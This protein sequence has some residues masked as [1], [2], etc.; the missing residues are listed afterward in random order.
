MN[1]D[2]TKTLMINEETKEEEEQENK[3]IIKNQGYKIDT[4]EKVKPCMVNLSNKESNGNKRASLYL[5]HQIES[6]SE[7]EVENN[8]LLEEPVIQSIPWD[9]DLVFSITGLLRIFHRLSGTPFVIDGEIPETTPPPPIPSWYYQFCVKSIPI[10]TIQ[11]QNMII[12]YLQELD[13]QQ[14]KQGEFIEKQQ[15]QMSQ[16]KENKETS[17][18]NNDHDSLNTLDSNNNSIP[19]TTTT[20]PPTTP[21]IDTDAT[22]SIIEKS[23]KNKSIIINRFNVVQYALDTFIKLSSLWEKT[24][25]QWKSEMLSHKFSKD[26]VPINENE[27][28]SFLMKNIQV[29]DVLNV[30]TKIKSYL[31][32]EML[33]ECRNMLN[34]FEI[35]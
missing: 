18:E 10:Y 11:I 19:T 35:Q 15:K 14:E 21:K 26:Q 23:Q 33:N 12:D 16:K 24:M 25:N 1:K 22:I 6:E 27:V 8:N 34:L 30:H 20:T 7:N 9:S 5:T 17:H 32:K 29:N 3:N 13:Y 4:I 31:G 2:N 28:D